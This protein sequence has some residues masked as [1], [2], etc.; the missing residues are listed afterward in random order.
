MTQREQMERLSAATTIAYLNQIKC[1]SL[2]IPLPSTR[3]QKIII[4]KIQSRFSLAKEINII[5]D[6]SLIRS[7]L[8]HQSILKSAFEGKLVPQDP[9]DEPASTLL[10][11]IKSERSNQI[12]MNSKRNRADTHQMRLTQ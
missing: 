5:I 9:N 8:L 12:L 10:E 1:N 2:T 3:E 11:R 7:N 6:Q 4:E